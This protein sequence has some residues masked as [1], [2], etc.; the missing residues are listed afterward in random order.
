MRWQAWHILVR[1]SR[2]AWT[3]RSRPSGWFMA[4]RT[5]QRLLHPRL[6]RRAHVP[7]APRHLG[8]VAVAPSG[9][10]CQA[11]Q[12]HAHLTGALPDEGALPLD[13]DRAIRL[14]VS[15]K[16][17]EGQLD[18]Q[19][20][21]ITERLESARAMLDDYRAREAGGVEKRRL[22]EAVLGWAKE[23]GQ[24]LDELT[25]EQRK[26][27][28]QMVV[29]QV[30]ID[31]NNNVDITLA[32]PI[33]EDTSTAVERVEQKVHKYQPLT[34]HQ[35][36]VVALVYEEG[37]DI[38]EV[39]SHC[40]GKLKINMAMDM[41]T[42]EITSETEVIPQKYTK[43]NAS[44]L[45]AIP[46]LADSTGG[47]VTWEMQTIEIMSENAKHLHND[48]FALNLLSSPGISSDEC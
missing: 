9:P 22:M 5:V 31:R 40:M 39:A 43:G 4:R 47:T 33:G 27:I 21:F 26:E 37:T 34:E 1:R 2:R 18:L 19:R 25:D 23:I 45:W 13:Q 42:G 16:I 44:L 46:F 48:I 14:F 30:V 12:A 28:L 3:S 6:D 11:L 29:E 36:Y 20:R 15:G 7:L 35:Y 38:Q 32:I 10:S 24:G 8:H 17:T 41:N